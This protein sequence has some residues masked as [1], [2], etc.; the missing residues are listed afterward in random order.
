MTD[1]S[2]GFLLLNK[3]EGITSFNSLSTVKKIFNTKK[4]GHT[5]TL[6]KFASG[7]LLVLVGRG[8]KLAPLFENCTKEYIATVLFGEETDTLDPEGEVIARGKIPQKEEVEAVLD[9][10]R[11]DI[12]Q[13]P[14]AYSAVHIKGKRAYELAREGKTPEMVK[15]PVTIYELNILSFVEEKAEIRTCVSA[16]TYIRSLARDIA[17]ASGSRAFLGALKRT[18][19]GPFKL[20]E[21]SNDENLL[22]ALRPLDMALF[23]G[24]SL[25]CILINKKAE[26]VF[27]HGGA[28]DWILS[29]AV[30][31]QEIPLDFS[32][33]IKAGVFKDSFPNELLGIIERQNGKWVYSHV[34][35]DC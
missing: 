6:D 10:F 11:G 22:S 8:V 3:S 1:G 14:P 16:G 17:I 35:A 21:A 34:F 30:F 2:H 18:R 4:V 33:N 7:L 23:E 13:A 31:K 12:L 20:E 9:N 32:I 15:R 19:I 27:K 25:P 29:G 26:E 28:L 24:L 5:G